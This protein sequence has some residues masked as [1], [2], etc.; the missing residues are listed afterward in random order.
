MISK[1]HYQNNEKD[2]FKEFCNAVQFRGEEKVE[3][4]IFCGMSVKG[5]R[6]FQKKLLK[7]F[8]I[9]GAEIK[10]DDERLPPLGKSEAIHMYVFE[11]SQQ[12][13]LNTTIRLLDSKVM[14]AEDR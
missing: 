9:A 4:Y 1:S 6:L 13:I 3:R 5:N 2:K 14:D 10:V 11:K 8:D 12:K 7:Q